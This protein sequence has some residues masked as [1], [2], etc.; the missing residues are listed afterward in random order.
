MP[1]GCSNVSH[2]AKSRGDPRQVIEPD[3]HRESETNTS[4]ER[5]K[6]ARVFRLERGLYAFGLM[7]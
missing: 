3:E 6:A 1:A 7:L 2:T 4:C 5:K